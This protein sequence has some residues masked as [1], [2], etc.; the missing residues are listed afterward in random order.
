EESIL[1][2]ERF[3]KVFDGT[4]TRFLDLQRAEEQTRES[5]IQLALERVR[6]RTSAMQKSQE[7]HEVIQLVFDQLQQLNFE[8]D[9]ANFSLKYQETDDLDLWLAVAG[10]QYATKICIP[11]FDHPVF[12]RFNK[13]KEK[14]GL[15]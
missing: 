14:G 4:Y 1:L 8:I 15:F 10:A 5:K 2:L 6:A 9:V 11:Y 3:A 13:A 12:T 7:L